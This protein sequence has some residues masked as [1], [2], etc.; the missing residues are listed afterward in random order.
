M[1]LKRLCDA[2]GM[3]C[4]RAHW[5]DEVFGIVTDSR[6]VRD[7]TMFVCVRG[8][9]SDGHDFIAD[10]IRAGSKWIVVE[11]D[12]KILPNESVTYLFSKNV[13][14]TLSF[15]F[16]EWF[17]RPC[18]RLKMIGV[19][20]T[21]G[22]STVTH[23]I[24]GILMDQGLKCGLIGTLGCFFDGV[25][26]DGGGIGTMTTPDPEHLYRILADLVEQNAEY[27]IMEVSS[28]ALALEKVAPI[29]FQIAVFTNLTPEHLDFH[30]NMKAYAN[31]KAKLFSQ[32]DISVINHDS[33]Y[34]EQ[35]IAASM[36]QII[37]CS[38][39]FGT[40]DYVADEISVSC[41]GIS[42]RLCEKQKE[43]DIFSSIVG[44]FHIMNSM[45]A[46]V[47]A[48]KIGI[49]SSAVSASLANAKGAKGRMERVV[50]PNGA[51]FTVMIDFAHTPDALE[52]LLLTVNEI[53]R[54]GERIVLLFGCGGDRDPYKRPVMGQIA[55]VYADR[56][57]LTSDNCRT[58]DREAI[59]R[60]ILQG[61]DLSTPCTVISDR[62][63]AIRQAILT[64]QSGD[65]ILLAGKGHEEYEIDANGCHPFSET[66]IVY[67]AYAL[68]IKNIS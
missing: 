29:Q 20:G 43:T 33:E 61:F 63:E 32:S 5:E 23:L 34:A 39:E 30:E 4:P 10:A 48:L 67:D 12:C 9:H 31:A 13:R 8:F 49:S 2:A 45:Q 50:L 66:E 52:N 6:Q 14:R 17:E 16:Y 24:A 40:C 7:G 42:Y 25:P 36:G 46:A 51:P 62:R 55:S 38:A 44:A 47:C 65:I 26:M 57:Y 3:D 64:A 27:V 54:T 41:D 35:M 11:E 56:V 19:T 28:H 53:R 68:R 1:K 15:L 18:E 21:N 37:T 22:K 60:D 59:L 58:E